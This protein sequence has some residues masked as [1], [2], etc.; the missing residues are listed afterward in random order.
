MSGIGGT[1]VIVNA[2]PDERNRKWVTFETI[3]VT[4]VDT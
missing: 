1:M 2:N 4:I 3:P